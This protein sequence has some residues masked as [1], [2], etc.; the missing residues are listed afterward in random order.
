MEPFKQLSD[1]LPIL[2]FLLPGFVS[3]GIVEMLVVRKAKAGADVG[4]H[5]RGTWKHST[6]S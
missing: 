3:G 6:A 1:L 2:I 5:Q 4:E